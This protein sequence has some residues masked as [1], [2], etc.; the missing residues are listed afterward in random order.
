M[1]KINLRSALIFFALL[2][3]FLC[4]VCFQPQA[5]SHT[6]GVYH[7]VKENETVQMIARA[8]GVPLQQLIKANNIADVDHVKEGYVMFIPSATR[9]IDNIV[10]GAKIK[11]ANAKLRV[12]NRSAASTKNKDTKEE[13][14]A[15]GKS[16]AAQKEETITTVAE[17]SSEKQRSKSAAYHEPEMKTVRDEKSSD[18]KNTIQISEPMPEKKMQAGNNRF[19][20]P[21]R[22]EVKDHFGV[23]PNKTFHNWIK[24]ISSVGAKVKAAES[25][26]VIFSSKL[27]NYGETIIVRHKDNFATVYTH[28]KKRYVKIDKNVRKGETIA[29]LGETDDAGEAYINFEIRVKGKAHN[30]LLFLP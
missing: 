18:K 17:P 8:Y 27:K 4:F 21:V 6:A 15:S 13:T 1:E 19:I 16:M 12:K 14:P 5:Q 26:T 10:P 23:Q 9:V 3:L 22:G 28:L 24:I 7:L 11:D 30:P 25:G 20:W 29:V 2:T